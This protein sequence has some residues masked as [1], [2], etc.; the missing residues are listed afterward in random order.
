LGDPLHARP[1]GVDL[2]VILARQPACTRGETSALPIRHLKAQ[3]LLLPG[4]RA[5]AA[6][7]NPRLAEVLG[8]AANRLHRED[9]SPGGQLA[10]IQKI[11]KSVL[12]DVTPPI[13]WNA[14]K[15]N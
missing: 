9:S 5:L 8:G 1:D 12:H 14:K 2:P 13:G 7:H 10:A 15:M 4:D 3:H 6:R 11:K